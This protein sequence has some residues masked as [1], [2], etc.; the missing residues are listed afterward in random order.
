MYQRKDHLHNHPVYST[1][2]D[3]FK[4]WFYGCQKHFKIVSLD[5][6]TNE[7]HLNDYPQ[8]LAAIVFDDG[9]YS[10]KRNCVSIFV[11]ADIP[12]TIFVNQTAVQENWLCVA[13]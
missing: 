4:G 8:N 3:V 6:I 12:F 7:D 13:I 1:D 10:L 11:R 2:I 5:E 9:F